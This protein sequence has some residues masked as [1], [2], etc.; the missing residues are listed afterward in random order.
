MSQSIPSR[1][2]AGGG[3]QGGDGGGGSGSGPMP[4]LTAQRAA[5]QPFGPDDLNPINPTTNAL[6]PNVYAP[7]A[8]QN[9]DPTLSLI[10]ALMRG[11][12]I[13]Q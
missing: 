1:C 2:Y 6:P 7:P 10:L 13:G 8:Q 4:M 3:T 9:S 5:A 11:K 12:R